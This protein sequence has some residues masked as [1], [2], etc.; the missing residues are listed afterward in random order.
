MD[1]SCRHGY[2]QSLLFR[3]EDKAVAR[4]ISSADSLSSRRQA[5][6]WGLNLRVGGWRGFDARFDGGSKWF[7]GG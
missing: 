4:D 3:Q 7:D 5:G 1:S 6:G 2:Q